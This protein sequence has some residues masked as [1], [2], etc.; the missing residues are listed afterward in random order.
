MESATV[1]D[2]SIVVRVWI[3]NG[4]AEIRGRITSTIDD[5]ETA[6]VGLDAIDD[7]VRTRLQAFARR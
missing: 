1:R 6:A 5:T 2:A 3:G 4:E 7:A